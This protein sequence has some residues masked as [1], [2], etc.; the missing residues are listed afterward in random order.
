MATFT[1]VKLGLKTYT[2][3]SNA[4]GLIRIEAKHALRG[5]VNVDA[6]GKL[7]NQILKAVASA[8]VLPAK[9]STRLAAKRALTAKMKTAMAASV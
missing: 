7:A 8:R 5:A 9:C 1:Q 6:T 3:V 4:E 2:V